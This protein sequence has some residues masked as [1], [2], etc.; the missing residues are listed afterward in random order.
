M[1]YMYKERG[2]KQENGNPSL[3]EGGPQGEMMD[4]DHSR[5]KERER[6][7]VAAGKIKRS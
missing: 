6:E 5:E 1:Y 4:D 3:I 2:R 7:D